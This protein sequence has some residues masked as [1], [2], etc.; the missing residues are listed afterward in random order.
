MSWET[1]GWK[2]TWKYFDTT[3][4]LA[5]STSISRC[6]TPLLPL[7]AS[8]PTWH[9]ISAALLSPR[10]HPVCHAVLV[11]SGLEERDVTPRCVG[12]SGVSPLYMCPA[13]DRLAVAQVDKS[14]PLPPSVSLGS[15]K[16]SLSF[17]CRCSSLSTYSWCF[18]G[19]L[20]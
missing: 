11:V 2:G 17:T 10:I 7:D 18:L 20:S 6:Q 13:G 12:Q 15:W 8:W 19:W 5:A 9:S 16:Y 4:I 14:L 3:W 1:I